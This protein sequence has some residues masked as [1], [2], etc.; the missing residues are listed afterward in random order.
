MIT[1]ESYKCPETIA[2][3]L[4][5]LKTGKYGIIAGGT[6]VIPQMR[7]SQ[8]RQLLDIS[9]LGLNFIKEND[10]TIEI[11]AAV[12]HTQL[13]SSP[14]IQQYLS[15]LATACGLV[16]SWQI[17]NRGTVGG[18]IV[19]ASPC[20]DSAPALLIYN[21]KVVLLS[22]QG[23]RSVNLSE[24]ISKPYITAITSKELLHSFVCQKTDPNA[25][26]FFFKLGRRQA[27]N[28]SRMTLAVS[29]VKD[30]N[31][32][33]VS[34][35]IAVGSVFPTPSRVPELENM[36]TDQIATAN[37]FG[38]VANMAAELMIKASGVRWS[39]PYK[40]PVLVGLMRRALINAA[41]LKENQS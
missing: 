34:A 29:L 32:K 38:E 40:K 13:N 39:T 22:S 10:N 28:I 2:E 37:L 5:L 24:F 25:G 30:A 26:S 33:I 21:A 9:K 27:V 7:H 19:N 15:L 16:G 35:Q 23:Q 14:L 20:A 31:N 3:A 4:K 12:T 8:A 11:G 36:L 41:G 6:D 17:R 1:V 18:N